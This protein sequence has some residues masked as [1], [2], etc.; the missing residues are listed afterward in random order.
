MRSCRTRPS[1]A[2]SQGDQRRLVPLWMPIVDVLDEGSP[3]VVVATR[4]LHAYAW[5]NLGASLPGWPERLDAR[6]NVSPASGTSTTT[7]GW[8]SSLPSGAGHAVRLRSG[9]GGGPGS[10]HSDPLVADVRL[11][12]DAPAVAW[13]ATTIVS[14]PC[15]GRGRRRRR[16]LSRPRAESDTGRMSVSFQLPGAA[17][18][19]LDLFD[20]QGGW[21]RTCSRRRWNPAGI[22]AHGSRGPVPAPRWL[23]ESTT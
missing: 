20:A 22:S 21:S 9:G 4:D 5:T 7:A 11:Q 17:A 18:V 8:R 6:C 10:G 1:S 12:P 13:R 3:D 14:R 15:P 23:L 19:R 16:S 2:A